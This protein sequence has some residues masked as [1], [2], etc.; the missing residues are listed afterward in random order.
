[1]GSSPTTPWS[2]RTGDAGSC[3]A[4]H[5]R[6]GAE[7]ACRWRCFSS[8]SATTAVGS[9]VRE[10]VDVDPDGYV[11]VQG[12]YPPSTSLPGVFAPATWWIRTYRQAVTAA[13]SGCAAAIDAERWL[14]ERSNR[15]NWYRRIDI[16]AQR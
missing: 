11:L 13:G 9:L 12:A 6:T 5:Q 2:R 16:R 1:M 10:A 7:T 15:L 3:G 8:R 14:A 4:R